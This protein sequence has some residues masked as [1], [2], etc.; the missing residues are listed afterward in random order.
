MLFHPEPQAPSEDSMSIVQEFWASAPKALPLKLESLLAVW[1]LNCFEHS[2]E[3]VGFSTFF[4]PAFISHDCRP[5][6]M[7]HYEGDSFILRA[8]RDISVGEEITVS[9]LAEE[10]LL[11]SITSRRSQLEATKH[12]ICN[13]SS[14]SSSLDP[15]R[16]FKC[17]GCQE[18]E[19]FFEFDDRIR[20]STEGACRQCGFLATSSQAEELVAQEAKVEEYIQQWDR[21]EGSAAAYLT[22]DIA[23]RLEENMAQLFS[24]KHWLRDRVARWASIDVRQQVMQPQPCLLRSGAPTSPQRCIQVSVRCRHGLWRPR[25]T[26]SCAS[27]AL[28]LDRTRCLSTEAQVQRRTLRWTLRRRSAPFTKPPLKP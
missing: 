15:V 22:E 25:V 26:W 1:L 12:F 24:E 11:E 10:S 14:C 8:R 6:C 18:G 2:E 21:K 16:G 17:L 9:Y 4:L 7:W 28:P 3:P 5:N 19:I 13:C 23:E 20:P 27:R